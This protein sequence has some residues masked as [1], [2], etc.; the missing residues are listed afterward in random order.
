MQQLNLSPKNGIPLV[1]QVVAG[2]RTQ[3]D[4]RVLRV[5]ARLP[6]IR[7][8]AEMHGISRFTVVEAYDRLVACG[9]LTARR[10][11]GFFVASGK[12]A[13]NEPESPVP[14]R[15]LAVDTAWLIRQALSAGPE[16][17]QAS[18]GWLPGSWLDEEQICRQMRSMLRGDVLRMTEY[19]SPSGY[20]PL[21]QH[22]AFQ[23]A[24]QGI[25]VSPSSILLTLGATQ[26][27]DLVIRLLLRRD[28][29]VLVD[30]PGYFALFGNQRLHGV[31]LVG[32]PWTPDGP[33][34]DVLERLAAEYRPKAYFTQSVLQNPT[35]ASLS[36]SAAFRIL[37]CAERYDFQLIEDDI[38]GDFLPGTATRLAAMDQLKRVIYVRSFSKMLSGNLRV[39]FVAASPQIIEGL[40]DIKTLSVMT[41]SSFTEELV[42]RMLTEGRYRKHLDRL[43]Q[44][45]SEASVRLNRML[46]RLG[47][48]T[49]VPYAGGMFVWVNL[50]ATVDTTALA[51]RAERE[52]IILAP[53]S[54]FRPQNQASSCIRLNVATAADVRLE[55]FLAENLR[56]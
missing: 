18:S 21:R 38:Y 7:R 12:S 3:I 40:T 48:S 25:A 29:V 6:P 14:E 47:L 45:L 42:F 33:D 36:P 49:F 50:L 28:D 20:E 34:L 55:R 54:M 13:S 22:L 53:G 37:Q 9:Y 8:F 26:A 39:G 11:S 41:T 52:N 24:E 10:G 31:R 23:L 2:L 15:S 27:L 51:M 32:V 19:G 43:R 44:R 4:D 1:E 46:G 17:L 35:G 5:G 30:D 16:T 56:A